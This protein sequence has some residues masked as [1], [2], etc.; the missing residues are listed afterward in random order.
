MEFDYKDP[1]SLRENPWNP[2]VV[3]PIN[4]DK[5][6][7]SIREHGFFK[8][9]TVRSLDNDELEIIA[10][11]HRVQAAISLGIDSIPVNILGTISDG[12]AKLL[13]QIDNARYGED[14][15]VKLTDLLTSSD[16]TNEDLLS[17]LPI[18]EEELA[19]YM[20][21]ELLDDILD[22]LD[23]EVKDDALDLEVPEGTKTHRIVRFKLS[24]EDAERLEDRLAQ[25]R[26]SQG[27]TESDELTNAGDA[28]IYLLKNENN[29][30][31]AVE[32]ARAF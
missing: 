11:A 25:I 22:D 23:E 31:P 20:S 24:M 29:S 2:N 8:P 10:G 28:L 12:K 5:I 3:D 15:T 26:H 1:R 14:D 17:Q 32:E 18:T 19:G 21:H 27:F 7:N 13:G 6:E 30:K 4:Q 16:I 9:V